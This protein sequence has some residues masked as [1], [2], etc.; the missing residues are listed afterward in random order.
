M[1][2]ISQGGCYACHPAPFTMNRPNG[3]PEY[4]LLLVHSKAAF[5][6]ENQ[7][8]EVKSRQIILIK[9]DCPYCYTALE[10]TYTDDWMHVS[11][12]ETDL[13][14]QHPELCN[15]PI[16]VGNISR[17]SFYMQQAL[18]ESAYGPTN[19]KDTN[20]DFLM[21]ILVNH[22][23]DAVN[24]QN[25]DLYYSPYRADFQEL[26]MKLDVNPGEDINLKEICK[27]M[28]ISISYFQHLYTE[29]FGISFRNDIIQMRINY[30][31]NLLTGTEDTVQHIA[32]LCGYHNEVH[33]YRQF[34][35]ITGT[36]PAEY[37]RRS[38]QIPLIAAKKAADA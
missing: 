8:F 21:Q 20:I 2:H 15:I 29:L 23:I 14:S 36:T 13:L 26:R 22:L 31:Q 32:L 16:T 24:P 12:S 34:R 28:H 27:T 18:W 10:D 19:S 1:Y 11:C 33:F 6:V 9:P 37:R 25:P 35:K 17:V 7:Q 38:R 4:L 5:T 30:A 3:I